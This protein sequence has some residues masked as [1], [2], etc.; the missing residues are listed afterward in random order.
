MRHLP[1]TQ[2]DAD[3]LNWQRLVPRLFMMEHVAQLPHVDSLPA[4]LA[5][6][7]VLALIL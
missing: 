5:D 7:E 3:L 6:I 4:R 2:R 1:E